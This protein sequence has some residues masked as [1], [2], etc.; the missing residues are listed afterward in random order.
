MR[1]DDKYGYFFLALG[2]TFFYGFGW[3]LLGLFGMG[4]ALGKFG[5]SAYKQI[6]EKNGSKKDK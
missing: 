1:D 6:K 4:L 3:K 2:L 5:A